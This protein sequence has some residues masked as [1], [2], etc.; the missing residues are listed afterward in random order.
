VTIGSN[1]QL[2]TSDLPSQTSPGPVGNIQIHGSRISIGNGS[3][4]NSEGN[5]SITGRGIAIGSNVIIN[6]NGFSNGSVSYP[7]G[8]IE[9]RGKSVSVGNSTVIT[10]NG[11]MDSLDGNIS[12]SA[13]NEKFTLG[14]NLWMQVEDLITLLMNQSAT[15]ELGA[16]AQIIGGDISIEASSGNPLKAD[17]VTTALSQ[18][19]N[20]IADSLR[21]PDLFSIPITFQSWSPYS[22]VTIGTG[23]LIESSSTIDVNARTESTAEGEA[24]WV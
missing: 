14:F 17:A 21:H 11:A 24:A 9:I 19:S 7:S 10:A 3:T 8:S 20:L 13:E 4:A 2:E 23:A 18:I 16:G 1:V 15:V 22:G 6:T 5:I 12:I